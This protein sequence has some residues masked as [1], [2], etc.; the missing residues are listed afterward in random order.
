MK[1]LTERP[2]EEVEERHRTHKNAKYIEEFAPDN[3]L[4]RW[5]EA[6]TKFVKVDQS[7]LTKFDALHNFTRK[8]DI[9]MWESLLM[10][11]ENGDT[12]FIIKIPKA[13]KIDKP[14]L[15]G[16][17]ILDRSVIDEEI[18]EALAM[19]GI[20]NLTSENKKWMKKRVE[21]AYIM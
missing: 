13:D 1:E 7:V 21:S 9:K 20:F 17:S 19:L 2:R 4:G 5:I 18:R 11:A 12:E 14:T 10:A 15:R 8:Y 6:K 16:T 3:L